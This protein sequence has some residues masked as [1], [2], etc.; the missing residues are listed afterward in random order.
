[1]ECES[2]IEQNKSNE[3]PLFR[4]TA[5]K[6]KHYNVILIESIKTFSK[7]YGDIADGVVVFNSDFPCKNF[8]CFENYLNKYNIKCI[9]ADEKSLSFAPKN[10]AW[11][12]YPPRLRIHTHEIFL[13]SDFILLSKGNHILEF[14]SG[15]YA[16]ANTTRLPKFGDY[17]DKIKGHKSLR[18]MGINGGIFGFPPNYD[19][20]NIIENNHFGWDNH[21]NQQGL[22]AFLVLNIDHKIIPPP[23]FYNFY[24]CNC[25]IITSFKCK[26]PK[27]IY[28]N[29]EF[30]DKMEGFHF[31]TGLSDNINPAW[32]YYAQ[33]PF[34][35]V[36]KDRKDLPED[37]N[38][39]ASGESK[40][41]ILF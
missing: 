32:K 24:N 31:C 3:K 11:K 36:N 2:F 41:S 26:F 6:S 13:D 37:I 35:Q 12:F 22:T 10:Y 17:F 34:G 40:A 1:M 33:K 7:L 27:N 4:W 5:G 21:L 9:F 15:S 14:L 16:F 25:S 8:K 20:K 30:T 19:I 28:K 23:Y 18:G 39:W 38:L 29:E